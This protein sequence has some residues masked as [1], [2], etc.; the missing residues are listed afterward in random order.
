[1][2]PA[3]LDNPVYLD[4][5]ATTATDPEVVE[6]MLPWFTE[7]FQNPSSPYPSGERAADAIRLARGEVA[8]LVGATSPAEVVFTSGG[9][10]AIASAFWSARQLRPNRRRMI[11]STVEHSAVLRNADRFEGFGLEVVRVGVDGQG[12]L[13]REALLEQID[14]QTCLVSLMLANN[15]TGVLTN[16]EGIGAACRAAGATFHLDGI[17][18]PGKLPLDLPA[19]GADLASLSAHKLHGPKGIGALW[20]RD[21]H[22]LSALVVGGPQ[23][24]ERRAGTE[25]VPG[26]VG[27]GRAAA[28]ARAHVENPAE[29]A[30][31]AG[32]R[33]RLEAGLLALAGG[34]RVHGREVERLGNTTNLYVP[35]FDARSL[36]LMLAEFGVEASAGSACNAVSSGPSPV[37]LAMGC[38]GEE[39]SRSLR[40]SLSRQTDGDGIEAALEGFRGALETLRALD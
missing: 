39:A 17:Q 22:E 1:L 15:E 25:N 37:L 14:G 29:L 19:T 9:S 32:L 11:V 13:D 34:S 21:G 2:G 23:E 33:D 26:M 4:N 8:R 38:P 16:L 35:G 5:N 10:E 6:A 18:G 7:R 36:V 31:V 24:G 3:D 40:F 27:F 28:L 30:R 20:V 12:R